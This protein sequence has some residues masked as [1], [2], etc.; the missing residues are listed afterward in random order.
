MSKVM[1]L[2]AMALIF[3]GVL[4]SAFLASDLWRSSY[5]SPVSDFNTTFWNGSAEYPPLELEMTFSGNLTVG[6]VSV[7]EYDAF[8][9]SH[10]YSGTLVRIHS[11]LL[12][13]PGDNLPAVLLLHDTNGS[14][15]QLLDSGRALASQGYVV[16]L[17]DSPGCGLSTGPKPTPDA[18]ANLTDGPFSAYIYHD[19]IAAK[20]ALTVLSDLPYVDPDAIAVS[21]VSMGGVVTYILAAI[22]SRVKAAVPVVASGYLDELLWGG[23]LTNLILPPGLGLGNQ[24]LLDLLRYF[25]CRAYAS[26]LTSPTLVVAGTHDDFFFIEAVNKTYSLIRSEKALNIAPNAG[27]EALEDEWISSA[28]IWL[29]HHLKGFVG[30]LPRAPL[31]SAEPANFYTS[32]KISLQETENANVSVFYR[33]GLPGSRWEEKELS[34]SDL[35]PMPFL[36]TTVSYYLGVKVNGTVVSTTPVYRISV[37]PSIFVASFVLLVS[38]GAVLLFNWRDEAYQNAL[39]DGFGSL[40]FLVG[41]MVWTIASVAMTF[42][43]IEF[44]GRTSVSLLELWDRYALHFPPFALVLG[45][46]FAS[47]LAYARR[48]WLGGTAMLITFGWV[49][50]CIATF[51]ILGQSVFLSWGAYLVGVCIA[52]S[53]I[54][55]ALLKILRG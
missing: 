4:L 24:T 21:G 52:V 40:L 25:D 2:K 51:T 53:F 13:P 50:F 10:V 17:I 1:I 30:T 8:F 37:V 28:V 33:D 54:I 20:R 23:S 55:P 18:I 16:M 39:A 14:C 9:S 5:A 31:A 42:P 3:L 7:D 44:G 22:D 35:I 45:G 34:D 46:L 47:L 43:W 6:G 27:Q 48:M 29:D 11:I 36:P 49:Y 19:V 32:I 12:K 15:L 38:V 26:Q 41:L